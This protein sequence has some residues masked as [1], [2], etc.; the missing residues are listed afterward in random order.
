VLEVLSLGMGKQKAL[1]ELKETPRME[2]E[3]LKDY[4]SR[5]ISKL[6]RITMSS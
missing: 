2:D 4:I 6:D 5:V 3:D 1:K